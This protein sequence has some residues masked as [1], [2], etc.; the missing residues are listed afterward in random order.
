MLRWIRRIALILLVVVLVALVAGAGLAVVT[1]RSSFPQTS[2]EV[3][4]PGLG[5]AV[6]VRR[7]AWGIPQITADTAEDL[8]RA[9]SGLAQ[10]LR[11]PLRGADG[12]GRDEGFR[13]GSPTCADRASAAR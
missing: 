9:A 13:H 2:G 11:W 1:V 12:S 7:D 8:P 4:V 6:E 5:A 3:T 10:R